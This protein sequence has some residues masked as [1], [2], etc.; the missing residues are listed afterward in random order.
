MKPR[1]KIVLAGLVA[2]PLAAI[3]IAWLGI[4]NVAASTGHWPI[5]N[6][7]LHFVMRSSVRTYALGITV[8]DLRKTGLLQPA[9]AHFDT[10]CAYCHGAPGVSPSPAALAMLPPPPDLAGKVGEWTDAEL[11]RI[12]RHG[13]RYTGM[14]AW[15][16]LQ[17]T[18]E[19]W[20]MVAFLRELPSLD[21]GQYRQLVAARQASDDA[22]VSGFSAD[23][24]RCAACHGTDGI[25]RDEGVPVIAG[26][27]GAYLLGSL[28][29]Y[30]EGKRPSGMMKVAVSQVDAGTLEKL[31]RYYADQPAPAKPTG[32]D[33][34]SA[35]RGREIAEKGLPGQGV[36]AC[37]GCHGGSRKN[38][39]YPKIAG[40]KR[41]YLEAQLRLFAEGHRGGTDYAHLMTK[42]ARNLSDRDIEDVA[43]YLASLR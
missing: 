11:F 30:A 24:V 27:S 38:P 5:T 15:P 12:V 41:A 7:F 22:R 3:F 26:Q 39:A 18:D 8:P 10:G 6:W 33:P 29:A 19:V 28:R 17:R 16:A 2:A 42:V 32:V 23:L 25:G 14:P 1:R 9:A 43:T 35:A 21:A 13:V 34:A 36:P 20:G 4:F 37:L 40:Q 31:A